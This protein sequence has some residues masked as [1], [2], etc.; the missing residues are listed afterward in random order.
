MCHQS[1]PII[2]QTLKPLPAEPY[3]YAE[4]KKCRAGIDYHIAI[5]RHYYSVPHQLVKKEL[6]VRITART[7]EAFHG[8]QR[9]ASRR[10]RVPRRFKD[11]RRVRV[12]R[13]DSE[14]D[15]VRRSLATRM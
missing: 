2:L 6:W 9:V 1:W 4:W 8:G 15:A 13:S 3:V 7:V 14:R 5:G 11:E 10:R 12:L